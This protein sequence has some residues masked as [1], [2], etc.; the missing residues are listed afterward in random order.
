MAGKFMS[1][2]TPSG[3][4]GCHDVNRIYQTFTTIKF[5]AIY[6]DDFYVLL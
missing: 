4:A 3:N 1:F 5:V 6:D 2:L